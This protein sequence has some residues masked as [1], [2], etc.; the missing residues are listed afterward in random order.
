MVEPLPAAGPPPG[1]AAGLPNRYDLSAAAA[2]LAAGGLLLAALSAH[3]GD[4]H[5]TRTEAIAGSFA[6][7]VLDSRL[8][9]DGV[10]FV[11]LVGPRRD[12]RDFALQALAAGAHALIGPGTGAAAAGAALAALAPA[13]PVPLRGCLLVCRDALAGMT[14]LAG[15]WRRRLPAL[16]IGVTGTNGK[17][18]TKDF[19]AAALSAA[20]SVHAT[21]GNLN[22]AEGVPLVLLGLQARH[23]Y[24]VVEM[25]A[26][27]VGHVA[28]RAAVA[29]PEIGVI[30][31]AAPAHLAEFG[32]LAGVIAGKG[33]LVAALPPDGVALLNADSPGFDAWCARAQCRVV[34]WGQ[35]AGDH[36]YQWRPRGGAGQLELDGELWD[37][38]LPGSHNGANLC[39]AVL[40]ARA[41]GLGDAQIR[42]GLQTFRPSPHRAALRRLSGRLVLDD[43]YN[44]NPESLRRAGGMLCDLPGGALWAVLGAMAE[45][46]DESAALHKAAGRDLAR[47]GIDHLVAVGEG[48]QLL[49]DGFA[50][51]GGQ[52]HVTSDHAAAAAL[53]A[54]ATRSGDRI[55]IKGS[56]AAAMEQVLAELLEVR[57]WSEDS[58]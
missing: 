6:G 11:G 1:L 40:A 37:V 45:L 48:A 51:S 58:G 54:A 15:H 3:D 14:C 28:A 57:G 2:D 8:A 42:A 52:A 39:A 27:A 22:S 44:A 23:R 13:G 24:A 18:T 32:N 29:R 10:L 36:R 9:T 38:P 26:S 25:G 17:T 46:G 5:V 16:V 43:C 35:R 49:A 33:E 47:L 34:S 20:G 55:L 30:T 19:L 41:A 56:R 21:T 53:L 12:G 31:N 50:A 7:A 4:W